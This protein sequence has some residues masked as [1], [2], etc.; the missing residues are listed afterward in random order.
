MKRDTSVSREVRG[1]VPFMSCVWLFQ[2]TMST[3][4]AH[5]AVVDRLMFVPQLAL[6]FGVLPLSSL[7]ARLPRRPGSQ[8]IIK[9]HLISSS[10][11]KTS[12]AYCFQVSGMSSSSRMF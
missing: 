12:P 10:N 6:Q 11:T 5:R 7:D 4:L 3:A 2:M 8:R 1:V 9:S